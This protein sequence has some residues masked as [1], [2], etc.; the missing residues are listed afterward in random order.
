M[1]SPKFISSEGH[2][3]EGEEGSGVRVVAPPQEELSTLKLHSIILR[4]ILCK[5][6]V[7]IFGQPSKL[8][9]SNSNNIISNNNDSNCNNT[10]V[11]VS[12]FGLNYLSMILYW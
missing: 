5:S 6:A 2:F 7:V 11:G 12:Y 10:S 8:F 9:D 3:P 1:F 4:P